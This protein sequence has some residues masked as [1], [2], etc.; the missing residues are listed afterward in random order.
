MKTN[1]AFFETGTAQNQTIL[2]LHGGG[3]AGWTWQPVVNLLADSFHCVVPDLPQHG[4]S[5]DVSPFTIPHTVEL[6]ADLIRNQA[7]R[8]KVVIVGLSEGAQVGTALLAAYP[9]LI[10]SAILSGVLCRPMPGSRWMTPGV[11]QWSQRWFVDPF[12][13]QDWYIRL[14]MHSAVG[15]PDEYFEQFKQDFQAL[16]I[17][18]WV[19]LMSANQNFRLPQGLE[20][21][22]SPV[23]VLTGEKEYAVMKQS[24]QDLISRLPFAQRAE[25]H[26]PGK[27]SLA[28]SHNWPL[29][30]PKLCADT[31]RAWVRGES[32]PEGI[33]TF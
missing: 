17:D 12:K 16:S 30:A 7:K 2:F 13:N 18:S 15:I 31:I 22:Q 24:A 27:V 20:K 26:L 6:T 32:L 4:A 21:Q 25:V 10:T 29:N 11:L 3:A 33:V 28:Q 5:L 1:L 8:G 23:L 9:E 14:N 19:N